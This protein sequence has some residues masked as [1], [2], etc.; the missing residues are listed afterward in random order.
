MPHM[1][2]AIPMI[3]VVFILV[4]GIMWIGGVPDTWFIRN[5]FQSAA[6]VGDVVY[7]RRHRGQGRYD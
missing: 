2:L 7:E 3:L 6:S 5:P 4:H 1:M